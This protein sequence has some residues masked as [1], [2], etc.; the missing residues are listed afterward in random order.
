LFRLNQS[1]KN[2]KKKLNTSSSIKLYIAFFF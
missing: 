2:T 1:T